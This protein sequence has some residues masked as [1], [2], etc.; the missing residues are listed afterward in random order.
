MCNR[1][2]GRFFDSAVRLRRAAE[3]L[4][5]SLDAKGPEVS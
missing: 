2:L 3:Y 1:G 4:E 5:K